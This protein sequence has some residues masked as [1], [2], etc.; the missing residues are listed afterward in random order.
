MF[1]I[2]FIIMFTAVYMMFMGGESALERQGFRG[3]N[4]DRLAW[5][6]WQIGSEAWRIGL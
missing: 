1:Y 4:R 2:Y 5:L 3:L 6:A